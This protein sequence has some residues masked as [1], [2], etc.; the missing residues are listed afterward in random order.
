MKQLFVAVCSLL[1][2]L[3][4][5]GC[6]VREMPEGGGI[7]PTTVHTE[8]VLLPGAD[9]TQFDVPEF[10]TRTADVH[11]YKVRYIVEVYADDRFDQSLQF[12]RQ[13][14]CEEGDAG[15][16]ALECELHARNY[17]VV[18]W[19]DFVLATEVSG[20]TA[21]DCFYTTSDFAAVKLKGDY[22]GGTDYK[23]VFCGQATLDLIPYRC[24]LAARHREEIQL[25]HPLAK[26]ELIT[27]DVIKYLNK[28][29]QMKSVR[30]AGIEDF[31]VQLVYTGYFPTGFNV[32]SNRPNEAVTGIQF[33]SVPIVVSN[34]EACLAFDYVLVNG[35]E[36]SVTL[37][38]VICNEKGQEVNRVGGVEVPVRRNRITTVRDAFLTREFAPGIGINPGFDGEINVVVP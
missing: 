17:R 2:A 37:E 9:M 26:I 30:P 10:S 18:A 12:R 31:T 21:A 38:M 13:L 27:T 14:I 11:K 22:T 35:T 3:L 5:G 7:D 23:D 19:R 25:E 6:S 24:H 28:L 32:V 8:I 20:N 4:W 29:E 36:S 16:V 33:T 1:S 34:N 15:E